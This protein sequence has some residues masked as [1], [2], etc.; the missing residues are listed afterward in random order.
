ME[1]IKTKKKAPTK[2]AKKKNKKKEADKVSYHRRPENLELDAW[3]FVLRKKFGE[4][5]PFEVINIGSH[6]AFSEFKVLNPDAQS[7]YQVT[8]RNGESRFLKMPKPTL[9]R[10]GNTCTCHDFRTN[11][12]GICKHISATLKQISAIRGNKK[13][14]KSDYHQ[15][16][17]FIYL[18]YKNGRQIR[19]CIGS[20]QETAF[21]NWAKKYFNTEGSVS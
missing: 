12:L 11:R 2:A 4:E 9:F 13:L 1:E 5:N 14:L 21:A 19:L 6:K 16:E 15:P 10:A 8:I 18:D 3:Q 20:E 17:S 7:G